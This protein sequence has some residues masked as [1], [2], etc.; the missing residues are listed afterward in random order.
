[1]GSGRGLPPAVL[2]RCLRA[3]VYRRVGRD[4]RD[5]CAERYTGNASAVHVHPR[6]HH[7]PLGIAAG[8]RLGHARGGAP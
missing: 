3:P 2:D 7:A 4:E 1:A 6:R 8:P 5:V